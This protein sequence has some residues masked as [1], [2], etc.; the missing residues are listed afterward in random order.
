[1]KIALVS[2]TFLPAIGGAEFVIH[3]LARHWV[4]QGHKVC[5]INIISDKQT[6]PEDGYDVQKYTILRGSSRFLGPHQIPF[7][8][9]AIRK[10]GRL[11]KEYN[12]DFVS[13]HMAYPVAIWLSKMKPVPKFIIT[14]HGADLTKLEHGFRNRYKI[15]ALLSKGLNKSLRAI[16]ISSYARKLMEEMGVE[17]A[18]I[19]DIPNGVDVERFQKKVNLDLRLK[20]GI[21]QDAVVILSVGREN[22]AKDFSTGI[23]AFAKF[24]A[25]VPNSY[26]VIVGKGTCRW[27]FLADELGVGGGVI[28][29]QGLFDDELVAAYQQA[30]IFFSC[31]IREL[32]PLVVLEGMASG[33]PVVVTDVSGSQDMI[34]TGINGIVV[35]PGDF[36][37][38]A[39]ALNKL[40]A[41]KSLRNSFGLENFN[42]SKNYSWENISRRYLEYA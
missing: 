21:P 39:E 17:P 26:Y 31:S 15:D 10:I 36:D 20:L 34:Q 4:F 6:H 42:K 27:L 41:D 24:H 40:S 2:T 3:N 14:C 9:D 12:P 29:V 33:L 13:A 18:K 11:L 28:F 32:C 22:P 1:M 23:K 8:L 35:E 30:D 5:V 38:M 25:R 37:G 7:R 19:V 16:A